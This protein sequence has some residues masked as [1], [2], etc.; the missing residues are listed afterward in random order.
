MR[1]EVFKIWYRSLTPDGKLWCES[2]SP[3]EVAESS[4]GMDCTFQRLVIE[5]VTNPW[6]P[7]TPEVDRSTDAQDQ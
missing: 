2:S 7:W 4:E 5:M 6:E 3:T 1:R